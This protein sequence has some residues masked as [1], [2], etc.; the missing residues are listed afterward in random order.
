[1]VGCLPRGC[2]FS[3]FEAAFFALLAC[4]PPADGPPFA[5]FPDARHGAM[6]AG[7]S[8]LMRCRS[9]YLARPALGMRVVLPIFTAYMLPACRQTVLG[10]TFSR[11]ATCRTVNHS[12]NRA[13]LL[14][15]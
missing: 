3:G 15:V 5:A 7:A 9:R 4:F 12:P 2:G 1:M 11:S 10:A 6:I 14:V 13:A 8:W